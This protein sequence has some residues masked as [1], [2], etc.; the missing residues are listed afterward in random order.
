MSTTTTPRPSAPVILWTALC[1]LLATASG[2]TAGTLR[3][4]VGPSTGH[5]S[6]SANW[7]DGDV[8]DTAEEDVLIDGQAGVDVLVTNSIASATTQT[9]GTLTIDAGDRLVVRGTGTG[10]TAGYRLAGLSN[11]GRLDLYPSPSDNILTMQVVVEQS[12]TT[13]NTA[14]G[15]IT[16]PNASGRNRI[17][18]YL[19]LE[20][21]NRNDGQVTVSMTSADR[22][23]SWLRLKNSGVFENNGTI[24][25][26][27]GQSATSSDVRLAVDTTGAAV[28]LSGS[29]AVTL[30]VGTLTD[31][32]RARLL[33]SSATGILTNGAAHTINGAGEVGVNLNLVNNGLIEGT[34]ETAPL[35][36]VPASTLLNTAAGRMVGSGTVGLRIG[37]HTASKTFANLGSVEART[38]GRVELATNLVATLNGQIRGGG[39][40]VGSPTVT[41]AA[42][43]LMPGDSENADGTGDST[44]GTLTVD[45]NLVFDA[46]STL[47]VQLGVAG[48][49]GADYDSVAVAGSLT[50]DGTVDVAAVGNY[51]GGGQY[52]ILSFAPGTLTDNGLAVGSVPAGSPTP[53][54][55]VDNGAGAVYLEVAPRATLITVR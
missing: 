3:T 15:V 28:T 42:A 43:T 48:T 35:V 12:G 25:V 19:D 22:D 6:A 40:F 11:S 13:F 4:W 47:A 44:V 30:D 55:V 29:G 36:L 46:T 10:A 7:S 45:G 26:Q 54:V 31:P 37:S 33:A 51:G 8:P 50:L 49:A 32:G 27:N 18:A 1:A 39:T 34:G 5:W 24:L 38:N 52:Q 20:A 16:M 23:R 21:E 17:N 2:L 9:N 41:L 14:S 53:R